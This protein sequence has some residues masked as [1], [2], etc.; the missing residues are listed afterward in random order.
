MASDLNPPMKRTPE[1]K[2]SQTLLCIIDA[3]G[4]W[5]TLA[6]LRPRSASLRFSRPAECTRIYT[7]LNTPPCLK[8]SR[9]FGG[10]PPST[11]NDSHTK[12]SKMLTCLLTKLKTVAV[13]LSRGPYSVR[14]VRRKVGQAPKQ[15]M[16]FFL[17][18]KSS[19]LLWSQSHFPTPF[20]RS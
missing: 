16:H 15:R 11:L 7:S 20:S 17:N 4:H 9:G 8:K 10:R 14:L 19:A 13:P 3:P 18:G 5:I 12:K 1:P 2:R 6:K